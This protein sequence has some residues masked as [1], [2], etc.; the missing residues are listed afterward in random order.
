MAV[1]KKTITIILSVAP[2]SVEPLPP[3]WEEAH[4]FYGRFR[5]CEFSLLRKATI[6][7]HLESTMY[8]LETLTIVAFTGIG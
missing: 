5:K 3:K 7:T 4:S 1:S 6:E 2:F 8:N